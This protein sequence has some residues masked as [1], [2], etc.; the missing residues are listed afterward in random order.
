MTDNIRNLPKG[1]IDDVRKLMEA[2]KTNKH[3]HDPVGKEDSDINNDGKVDSTDSYLHN[4][5]K[6]IKASMKEATV[7]TADIE[8]K[9][10]ISNPDK[11]KIAKLAAMMS[12]EKKGVKEEIDSDLEDELKATRQTKKSVEGAKKRYMTK[13]V[14]EEAEQIDELSSKTLF[15]YGKKARKE[16]DKLD[17]PMHRARGR[18]L[19]SKKTN[20]ARGG[21]KLTKVAATFGEEAEQIDELSKDKMLK[22]LAA[23]KKD[24]TKAREQGDMDRMTKRMRG[25]DMAV[26]KYTAKPG[27]KYVK[28]PATEAVEN[29]TGLPMSTAEKNRQYIEVTHKLG[30][31]KMVPV[32]P[33]NAFKALNRYKKDPSTKSARIVSEDAEQI[34][35]LSTKKLL[36]YMDKASDARGHRKLPLK[37]VDNRYAGV[38]KASAKLDKRFA[39]NEE[40]EQIDELSKGTLG[41]YIKKATNQVFSKGVAGG[42]GLASSNKEDEAAGHRQVNKAAKRMMGVNKAASKLSGHGYT[43][44]AANEEIELTQE[45]IERLNAIAQELDE[46]RGRPP[47]EGSAAWKARQAAA[48]TGEEEKSEPRQHIMQQ[49]QRAKLSMHGGG[50]VKFENGE[51]HNIKGSHAAKLIDKYAGMKPAE[52]E[53]FQKKIGKSHEHLKSEL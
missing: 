32:H 47:K 11:D 27:S 15:S 42:M 46:A 17:D 53:A 1:L 26:R 4:R 12:K 36:D 7:D 5:R 41:S 18:L 28:V 25:T 24:D 16:A 21:Y 34:D 45:E 33:T 40:A 37:K 22:Y 35:E 39:A 2:K 9:K 20:P 51:T 48:K 13:P 31:K 52:K 29:K 38:A 10:Y 19:A 50:D 23:N 30:H 44:V 14:K 8:K 6:A 43:K 3:G 49:L